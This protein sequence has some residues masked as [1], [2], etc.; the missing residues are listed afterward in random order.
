MKR[1]I[2]SIFLFILKGQR[3]PPPKKSLY[4][5]T[6]IRPRPSSTKILAMPLTDPLKLGN[7]H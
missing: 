3:E 1:P 6:K 7:S 4:N 5:T 2:H